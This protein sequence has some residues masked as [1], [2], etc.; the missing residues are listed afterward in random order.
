MCGA[1]L[2]RADAQVVRLSLLYALV[3]RSSEIRREHLEAALALWEY[4][5]ASAR[6]I[7]GA[8]LGDHVADEILRL[9]KAAPEGLTRTQ[10]SQ[11]FGGHRA[12]ADMA[13]AFGLLERNGLAHA[14]TEKTAG[15]PVERWF[16][17]PGEESGE[18]EQSPPSSASSASFAGGG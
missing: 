16:A 12:A 7:F 14:L 18:S 1:M 2:G 5:E 4:A 3:D 11:S 8:G 6:F 15:R 10:I 9:L 13:R 17:G